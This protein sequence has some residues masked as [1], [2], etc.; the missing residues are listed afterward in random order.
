MV[1]INL[2][3]ILFFKKLIENEIK[4]IMKTFLMNLSKVKKDPYKKSIFFKLY[5]KR[6]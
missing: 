3:T 2:Y 6:D 5:N 4:S 1:P